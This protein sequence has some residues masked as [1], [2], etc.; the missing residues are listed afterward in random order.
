MGAFLQAFHDRQAKGHQE[1]HSADRQSE[2]ADQ[3]RDPAANGA[4]SAR[5]HTS[6]AQQNEGGHRY[7]EAKPECLPELFRT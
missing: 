1:K 3:H 6:K 5:P 4:W 7:T 2:H